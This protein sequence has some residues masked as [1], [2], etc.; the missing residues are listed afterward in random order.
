M[1]LTIFKTSSSM[2]CGASLAA[3]YLNGVSLAPALSESP[4]QLT[5]C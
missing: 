5:D 3:L 4:I 2:I 1:K